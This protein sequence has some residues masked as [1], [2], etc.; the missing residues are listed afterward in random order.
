MTLLLRNSPE[1]SLLV[2]D[3]VQ[4]NRYSR[5]IDVT[6]RQYPGNAHGMVTGIELVNRVHSSGEAG[7]SL[8]LNF[9]VYASDQDGQ[10]KNDHSLALF[11]QV[12]VADNLLAR[13]MGQT[14]YQAHQQLWTLHLRQLLQKVFTPKLV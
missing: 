14:I 9:C 3:S 5:S 11:D 6:K 4:D 7:G 10:T 12:V 2:D 13:R 8:P 1:A